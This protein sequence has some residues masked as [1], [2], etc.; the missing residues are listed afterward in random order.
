MEVIN[1]FGIR[2]VVSEKRAKEMIAEGATLVE[3]KVEDTTKKTKKVKEEPKEEVQEEPAEETGEE[4]ELEG[5]TDDELRE[6]AK[7]KGI[8]GFAIMKRETLIEKLS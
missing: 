1:Q 6:I 3:P 2:S 4:S 8:K 7:E 5:K